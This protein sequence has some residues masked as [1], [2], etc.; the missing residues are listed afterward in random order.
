MHPLVPEEK[1]K[2]LKSKGNYNLCLLDD[3]KVLFWPFIKS[4]GIAIYRPI[5]L[6]LQVEID[7]ISCGNNFA[8]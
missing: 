3:G 6:P 4:N 1:V 7:Q 5:E 8:V 2:D